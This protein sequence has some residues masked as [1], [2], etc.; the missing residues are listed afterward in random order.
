MTEAV[1]IAVQCDGVIQI[2]EGATGP[3]M[4]L[5]GVDLAVDRGTLVALR[6]PSGSGKST[7]LRLLAGAELPTAGAIHVMGISP[8]TMDGR[9]RSR[10]LR[11]RIAYIFQ[12]APDNVIAELTVAE[13]IAVAARV[14]GVSRRLANEAVDAI[15]L[16]AAARRT[17]AHRLTLG[18]Q[19]CLS[20]V[21]ATVGRPDLVIADEPSAQ[22]DG[23][24]ANAL[25]AAMRN[26]AD[27]GITSMFATHDPLFLAAVDRTVEMRGGRVVAEQYG[28]GARFVRADNGG[29]IPLPAG[30][31]ER[32]PRGTATVAWE[33]DHFTVRP[34]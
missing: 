11:H 14:R 34:S 32:L 13:N 17:P 29:W 8:A 10:F 31:D 30:Y 22:M 19:Q 4:A 15:P 20:F 21:M 7:L 27:D 23:E 1:D 24:E 26:A 5:R 6:G 25:L 2:Y 18:R 9:E 28:A 33:A 12:H 16:L 3:T